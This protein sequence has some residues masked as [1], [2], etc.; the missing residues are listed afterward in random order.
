MQLSILIP[1][2]NEMFLTRTIEDILQN[3]EAETEI[4]A[5]LDGAWADPPIPQNERVNVIYVPEAIGQRS[6]TNLAAKLA[7][8]KYVIKCDAH[9]AFDKG[10]DRKMIEFMEKVGDDVT[11]VPVMKNLHAFSWNC[12][13]CNW[14]KYQ[15]PTPPKCE[16]CGGTNLRRKMIW[17]PRS[18]INSTSYCFDAEPHFQYH[19]AYK[20]TE[21]YIKDKKEKR[22]TETMSLQ[23]S[24][25]MMTRE[26]YQKF[27]EGRD[28]LGSW[29]NEGL[30]IACKTWLS[31]GRCL[32]NHDTWYAHL[33]RTQGGDFSFPY[34]QGG[35]EVSRTKHR[36]KD[37]FWNKEWKYQ[38]HPVSWLVRKFMPIEGKG[39]KWT[40][41]DLKNLKKNENINN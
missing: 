20:H 36:V 1:A 16:R 22:C 24:F 30:E 39:F 28:E 14:K 11:A 5:V 34:P 40:D 19:E 23:G 7:Q 35:R 27:A 33:F 26:Q 17:Q 41:G 3:S 4:I 18:G 6:G 2:R 29:G 13:D 31:G 25:F 21:Q 8:G 38:I 32:V 10:F 15:G 9:C 12:R 37:L